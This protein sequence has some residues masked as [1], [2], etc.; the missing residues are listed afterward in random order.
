MAVEEE[1]VVVTAGAA[2]RATTEYP[3]SLCFD[4]AFGSPFFWFAQLFSFQSE[5][6]SM[7]Y[8]DPWNWFVPPLVTAVICRPLDRPYSAWYAE[9][10]TLTSAIASMFIAIS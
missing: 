7:S 6:R 5:F 10:S 8:S 2:N 1:Q 9:V 3:Q 4:T